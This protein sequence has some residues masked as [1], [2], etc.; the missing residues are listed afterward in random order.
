MRI[1]LRA[2]SAILAVTL[3]T[4]VPATSAHAQDAGPPPAPAAESAALATRTEQRATLSFANRQIA[5]LHATVLLRSPAERA[6]TAV[7]VLDRLVDEA[8][9]GLV[10]T[11]VV[12]DARLVSIGGRPV[13]AIVPQDIDELA[14]ETVDEVVTAAAARLQLAFDE[15]VELRNPSR[16]LRS[17]L[18]ALGATAAYSVGVWLLVL[19]RRASVERM[20]QVA[21]RQIERLPGGAVIASAAHVPDLVGRS[22]T[23]GIGLLGLLLTDAWLTFVLTRFPYTRPWGESLRSSVLHAFGTAGRT[24]VDALPGLTVV[25]AIVVGTRIVA[26]LMTLL[27]RAVEEQRVALLG[28]HP[29]TAQSTRRIVV[30]MLWLL[31]LIVS[32]GYLPGSDSEAF[33]GV[34]VF[35]GLV[36]SLGSTGIMNQIMSGLTITY[37]RALHLGD[38]VKVGDVEGTVTHLGT[39]AM[40]IK[41]PK[42]EEITI[43]NAV[44][45]SNATTNFSRLA[46]TEGVFV[47]TS[48]TIG[49]DTPWRQVKALL[50]LAAARTP[51]LRPEPAPVVC[52]TELQDFCVKYTLLVCI[53]QPHMRLLVLDALHAQMQDAFNEYGV[54]IM[55]PHYETDPKT[56]KTV[57]PDR[58]FEAPATPE[59]HVQEASRREQ[60]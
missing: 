3:V 18:V 29:E 21:Q 46:A 38:F 20:R 10:T 5:Q 28:V 24:F 2:S 55:S 50:L 25:L 4:G 59:P 33:K 57:G 53:E 60:S 36:I 58:W 44:V 51:G 12:G 1:T 37:S 52:Q 8:P 11:S 34:S 19:L 40:K 23:V 17:G 13:F 16:L 54:Q 56:P 42:R 43:P 35:V 49:Y 27:F 32:Y 45:V 41:T 14:G 9:S 48:V 7:T 15:A 6:E 30:A 47:N 39:L 31:A 26:R 22:F